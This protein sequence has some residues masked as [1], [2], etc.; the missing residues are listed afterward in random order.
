VDADAP[1]GK[2]GDQLAGYGGTKMEG[3]ATSEEAARGDGSAA[4]A[5]TLAE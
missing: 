3:Y 4:L 1:L 5:T 2:L